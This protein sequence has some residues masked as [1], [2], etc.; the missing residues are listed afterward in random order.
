MTTVRKRGHHLLLKGMGIILLMTA[1]SAH[2]ASP[3]DLWYQAIADGY[4]R[5]ATST[6]VLSRSIDSYCSQSQKK[7]EKLKA[8]KGNW[9]SAFKAWQAVRFVDFG[10]IKKNSRNWQLQFWPDK[11]NLIG[12]KVD[13]WLGADAEITTETINQDGVALQGFPA[14]EYVLFDKSEDQLSP[15]QCQ[16]LAKISAHTEGVALSLET[17]WRDF[18]SFYKDQDRYQDTTVIGMMNALDKMADKRLA[19]PMGLRNN[20]GQ[21]NPNPYLAD[22]W[23]SGQSVAAIQ[24][25]L[26]GIRDYFLPGLKQTLSDKDQQGL[27]KRF[28]S[29]LDATIAS[30]NHLPAAMKPLLEDESGYKRLKSAYVEVTKLK[31]M[32]LGPLAR[33]LSV[34][35]GFNASDGD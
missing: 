29:Q 3:R 5:L 32:A 34:V 27:Y 2:A 16:L 33:E 10:P 11:K 25:S 13:Y 7:P 35:R 22:A 14:M 19:D 30:F 18:G 20:K 24:A 31:H 9:L 21:K 1:M 6:K 8:V 17:E 12:R 23:R 26:K 15:R 4:T 28:A